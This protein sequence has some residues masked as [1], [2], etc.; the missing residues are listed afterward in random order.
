M[1]ESPFQ[2]VVVNKITIKICSH[3]VAKNQSSSNA[4]IILFIDLP[5]KNKDL[6]L[7][8]GFGVSDEEN[9]GTIEACAK[10]G[11]ALK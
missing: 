1:F 11:V 6:F 2:A 7:M 9:A 10:S 5:N 8:V 4:R 3:V